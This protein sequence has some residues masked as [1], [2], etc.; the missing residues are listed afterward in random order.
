MERGAKGP[1]GATGP[2]PMELQGPGT[3]QT[4]G[5]SMNG[6]LAQ[7]MTAQDSLGT[8]EKQLGTPNMQL[9]RSQAHLLRSKLTGMQEYS[10]AAAGKLGVETPQMKPPSQQ[11]VLGRFIAYVNDGQDQFVAIQKKLGEMSSDGKQLSPADMMLIQTKMALAQ[12]EIE[13][14]STLLSKVVS[15]ITQIMGIQL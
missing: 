4:A 1:Q 14:S 3:M 15:S 11:G 12:Q 10:R 6:L 7:S 8:V 5:L 2:S 9:K 13:Y